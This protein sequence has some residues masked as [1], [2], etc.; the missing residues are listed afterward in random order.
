MCVAGLP[1]GCTSLPLFPAG[2]VNLGCNLFQPMPPL[3]QVRCVAGCTCSTTYLDG[4]W[5]Q[6]ATLQYIHRFKVRLGAC[7]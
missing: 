3:T 4:T 7:S 6:Q 2:V 5:E 1:H